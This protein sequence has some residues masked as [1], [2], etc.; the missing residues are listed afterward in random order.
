[1][2]KKKKVMSKTMRYIS[3]ATLDQGWRV[4]FSS[5]SGS[6]RRILTLL[7]AAPSGGSSQASLRW[8]L[9][10]QQGSGSSGEENLDLSFPPPGKLGIRPSP[11]LGIKYVAGRISLN[12]ADKHGRCS[13]MAMAQH[14]TRGGE[15]QP[16]CT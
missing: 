6:H 5:S 10:P 8:T 12:G 7:K 14:P 13:L 2:T 9:S 16:D 3:Y 4:P 11:E 15:G 1:M